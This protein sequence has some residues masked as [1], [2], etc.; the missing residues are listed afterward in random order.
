MPDSQL[1]LPVSRPHNNQQLFSDHYL[2]EVLPNRP[3]W[4]LQLDDARRAQQE[5]ARLFAAYA[6]SANEAQTEQDLVRPVLKALGHDF[7]VQPSLKTPQSTQKPDY[8]FYRNRETLNANKNRTLDD[9]LPDQ[10]GFAVGDA[11]HW[12]RSL[13][14]TL[15]RRGADPFSNKNPSYQIAFYI[16]HSGVDW[17]ILTNG[18]LWRLY[19]KESAHKLDHYYEVDLFALAQDDCGTFLYFYAFFRRAAF[20]E[21]PLGVAAVLRESVELARRVGESLKTQVY[22]ALLHLAQGFLDYPANSFRSDASA[23]RA[24]YDNSLIVL[25]RLLFILYA[26]DRDLLPVREQGMYRETYSLFAIKRSVAHDLAIGRHLLPT[27]ARLWPQ[28]RDLF[29]IIDRGSPPL[30]VGTFNGGLFDPGRHPFLEQYKIGDAHL[31]RAIDKL[32]RVQ[33]EFVDYRDLSVRHLGTIYEG[34]LENHL[35]Q[36]SG[37]GDSGSGDAEDPG[38]ER[39]RLRLVNDKGERKATGSYY[40]PDYIVMYIVEQTLGP[41]LNEAVSGLTDDAGRIEAVLGVNILDPA[42]GSGHFLVE[43]TEYI[44]RYL[45]DLDLSPQGAQGAPAPY[46]THVTQYP[47]PDAPP[48]GP[49]A[50]LSYW[51][52]RAA[53]SCIYGVDLN[54][55]AVELA[56]LSLWLTTIA[57][58]RPLSFLD[59]HL[60]TG[61]ALVGARL[62]DLQLSQGAARRRKGV[63]EA[64]R[65]EAA[66]QLSLLADDAF[67]QS[68]SIAVG[69]M[70]LI[71]GSESRTVEDVKQQESIYA[72]LRKDFTGKYG[73]LADLVTATHFGVTV[74][75]EIRQPMADYAMG[76][77]MTTLPQIAARLETAERIAEERRFF[78]WELEFPEVFFDRHGRPLGA[79]AGFDAVIGNPPYVRQEQ[80][81]PFKPYLEASFGAFHGVADLYLYFFERGLKLA[82]PGGRMAYISSGT[83]ARANFA[84]GLRKLL[85]TLAQLETLID[86]GE[87]QPFEGAE[88]VRPSIVVLRRGEHTKPFRSL[89][90]SERVPESLADAVAEQGIECAAEVLAQ[91]EWTFQAAGNTA[92][93]AKILRAG[94][95]LIDV[96]DGKMY[97]GVL[98]GLNEAFIIDQPTRDRLVAADPA[99]AAI[100]KPVLR[101]EDLRPWYQ[102]EEGR[103][104]IVMPSGWSHGVFGAGLSE[105]EAWAKLHERHPDVAGHLAQFAPAAQKR[106]DKGEYWWELRSCDYYD[107]FDGPKIFW[108]DISKL[109]R[110]SWGDPGLYTGNT[111][112]IIPNPEPALLG[113]LQSRAIWFAVSQLCQPLRL[114][115]GLWQYRILPQFISRLPIPDASATDRQAIGALAMAITEQARARYDLHRKAQHRLLT[116]FGVPGKTLNQKLTAWWALE[117][118]RLRAELQKVFKR[119]IHIAQRDEWES[120]LAER[121]AEHR[122]RTAEIVRLETELNARVYGLFGLTTAEIVIVEES[123]KYR[124]GEV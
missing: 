30:K 62:G 95:R 13:D 97:R 64:A 74:E 93:F 52:R 58:D 15:L 21:R 85:P 111:G 35:E 6:P 114:R 7:E 72:D 105:A 12:D 86:F 103:W 98:T 101:G 119:D 31:Q 57:R 53:Q 28:L 54:P 80:L 9:A 104:L 22:D 44:A 37:D 106:W 29:E 94:R 108:P 77:T 78:H 3:E 76:R 34:L 90:L 27:S 41:V 118:T 49:E 81:A 96:V 70:W 17:G 65:Q 100:I 60:R 55:L 102:E 36:L 51:R 66:G 10:G 109:P 115:A 39:V 123:T 11:K 40:T 24:V 26:E 38:E 112:Y 67:R 117:F 32:A 124:Y 8:I 19:H 88:M 23:L 107:A 14:T 79:D 4:R 63:T 68:M 99:S 50:D 48:A 16:Q 110:F 42:M 83:F 91:P 43:A 121:K 61:N 92:L 122:M 56:K 82:R 113:I 2:N 87:N 45:V 89:F 25:Y 33:G 120:W 69:N 47:I 20:D 46:P 84:A 5:I 75:P 73:R 18:R 71:E 59:H 1:P 116:D